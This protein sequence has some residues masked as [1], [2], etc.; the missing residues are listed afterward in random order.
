VRNNWGDASP[1]K[2][3]DDWYT[4]FLLLKIMFWK[5]MNMKKMKTRLLSGC[6]V[7]IM[8]MGIV[9]ATLSCHIDPLD[10]KHSRWG[11][12]RFGYDTFED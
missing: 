7:I 10:T 1:W 2:M 5:G 12:A 9:M 4:G 6:M 3:N 8:V 11:K